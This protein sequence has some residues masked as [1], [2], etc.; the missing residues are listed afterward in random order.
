MMAP[1][2]TSF[3][4]KLR[5]REQQG[6]SSVLRFKVPQTDGMVSFD[7]M[8]YGH[9]EKHDTLTLK[10]LSSCAPTASRSTF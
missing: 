8:V 2:G 10:T 9:I 7:D 4:L 3:R 6:L 5:E 1:A